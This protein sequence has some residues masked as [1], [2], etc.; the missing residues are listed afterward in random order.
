M[1][2]I[3]ANKLN[4]TPNPILERAPLLTQNIGVQSCTYLRKAG[5]RTYENRM[6]QKRAENQIGHMPELGETLHMVVSVSYRTVDLIP[7]WLALKAPEPIT[8]LYIATLSFNRGCLDLILELI[9]HGDV[10]RFAFVVSTFSK[11]L[12]TAMWN[13]AV[14]Q[15]R[16]RGHRIVAMFNH[17]KVI[18]ARFADGTAYTAEGSAN[19]RSHTSTENVAITHDLGLFEFHKKWMDGV[20]KKPDLEGKQR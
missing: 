5:K 12:E 4:R 15:I 1:L 19:I 10:E 16:G 13:Y 18:C 20:L 17:C 7:A 9:D 2:E 8:E 14:E 6:Y 3:S 11:N